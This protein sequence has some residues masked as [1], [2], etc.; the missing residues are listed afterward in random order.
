MKLYRNIA[1]I[2]RK[3]T[4]G[5]RLS[6]I[7]LAVLFIGLLASFVPNWYPPTGPAPS[8]VIANFL[9]NYWTWISFAALPAGFILASFG[10]Y[11]INR[12]ARRRWP[13][14]KTIARPDEL[15]ER[16]MKGFDDK[17]AYF[18]WSLPANHVLVGPCG[19]LVLAVR[20]DRGRVRVQGDRWREPFSIGRIFTVFAREGVGN[21]VVELEEQVKKMRSLLRQANGAGQDSA[22]TA[23]ADA[24]I[25]TAAVFLNP[26]MTLELDHPSITTLRADQVKEFVRRKARD[27]KLQP[28]TTRELTDF[29]VQNSKYQAVEEA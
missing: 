1:E 9:Y 8:G 17:Y 19:L 25:D 29:L 26:Q 3:E 14:I 12:F 21:P 23:L 7:G 16:S 10:S 15:L 11:F 6:L 5:R 20:S 2:K 28:Q 4:L 24:P 27:V 22:K 13:G 18:A